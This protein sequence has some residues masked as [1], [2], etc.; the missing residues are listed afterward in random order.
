MPVYPGALH[1]KTRPNGYRQACRH[2]LVD[3]A[4]VEAGTFGA[5]INPLRGGADSLR[6]PAS[7]SSIVSR[8]SAEFPRAWIPLVPCVGAAGLQALASEGVDRRAC[9]P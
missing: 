9:C 8:S 3:V 1:V 4:R 2:L 6:L 7:R 5:N